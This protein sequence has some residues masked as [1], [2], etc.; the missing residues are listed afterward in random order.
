MK[1]SEFKKMLRKEKN[2]ILKDR[3]ILF[4]LFVL[5]IPLIIMNGLIMLDLINMDVQPVV[6][7]IHWIIYMIGVTPACIIDIMTDVKIKKMYKEYNEG[8]DYKESQKRISKVF[9]IISLILAVLVLVEQSDFAY[10]VITENR[11]ILSVKDETESKKYTEKYKSI[12][13]DYYKTNDGSTYIRMKNSE[14]ERFYAERITIAKYIERFNVNLKEASIGKE[15][16]IYDYIYN[17][18]EYAWIMEDGNLELRIILEEGKIDHDDILEKG[19]VFS[20]S[21]ICFEKERYKNEF[22]K[23]SKILIKTD[24][25]WYSEEDMNSIY[26]ESEKDTFEKDGIFYYIA[27]GENY[28]L[29]NAERYLKESKYDENHYVHTSLNGFL[30]VTLPIDYEGIEA[31]GD[32]YELTCVNNETSAEIFASYYVKDEE[33]YFHMTAEDALNKMA[34]DCKNKFTDIKQ[35]SDINTVVVNDK[36]IKEATYSATYNGNKII[37][38]ISGFKTGKTNEYIV[39]VCHLINEEMYEEKKEELENIRNSIKDGIGSMY[40][41]V[42]VANEEAVYNKTNIENLFNINIPT[43]F[44]KLTEE[45]TSKMIWANNAK[46]SIVYS[47]PART[48]Y[49]SMQ[50]KNADEI[51]NIEEYI[52]LLGYKYYLEGG[53]LKKEVNNI[54]GNEIG[55][56]VGTFEIENT[57]LY[58]HIM[59][60]KTENNSV[61]VTVFTR[62]DLMSQWNWVADEIMQSIEY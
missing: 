58:S 52:D 59:L 33:A 7:L 62:R 1:K 19:E 32:Q 41:G 40:I 18:G 48:T 55:M 29:F 23:Y 61:G 20:S 10:S 37:Y 16:D 22:E 6:L 13:Y 21:I 49:I 15:L 44:E 53:I 57:E 50:I 47:N 30:E 31:E 36:E 56:V 26:E 8:K 27:E 11:P 28:I 25:D 45:E 54:N 34:E 14:F 24:A 3:R 12:F 46:P 51:A 43:S 39:G 60:F 38:K 2:P 5:I 9:I 35:I 42:K 4:I 17:D